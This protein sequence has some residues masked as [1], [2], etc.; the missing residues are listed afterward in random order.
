MKK[1]LIIILLACC[2]L[3]L[4][5][6]YFTVEDMLDETETSQDGADESLPPEPENAVD[7]V[8]DQVVKENIGEEIVGVPE[9]L[10]ESNVTEE[11]LISG[12]L[13]LQD[14]LGLC[15]H[16]ARSF[17]CDRYDIRR[18]DFKTFVGA[19]DFYPDFI[20]CKDGRKPGENPDH[21]YCLIQECRPMQR[22]NIVFAYG[23]H[24]IYAEY[25]YSVENVGGGI[26][27]HYTL[28]R[29]G[30]KYVEFETSFDCTVY[31]SELEIFN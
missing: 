21:K 3:I 15:P 30:E 12:D 19:N 18:C 1:S 10:N 22:D 7:E 26:I 14:D 9:L 17:E 6:T 27:T 11:I 28:H 8:I 29:C 2:F 24:S 25:V 20:S 31:K 16:L 5:C 13:Q 23:G 4:G